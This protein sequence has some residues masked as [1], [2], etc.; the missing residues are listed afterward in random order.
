MP[1]S[2][3]VQIGFSNRTHG[4]GSAGVSPP[5]HTPAEGALEVRTGAPT[6]LPWVWRHQRVEV[7]S[8]MEE[9]AVVATVSASAR[10]LSTSSQIAKDISSVTPAE[11]CLRIRMPRAG[12]EEL[13]EK[14]EFPLLVR[15]LC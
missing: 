15:S 5:S 4:T 3:S 8:L 12:T 10:A 7:L 13:S 11:G 6:A 2:F 14:T 1:P 9:V